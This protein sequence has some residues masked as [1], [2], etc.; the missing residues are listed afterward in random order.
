M[1]VA[2]AATTVKRWLSL[3][4]ELEPVGIHVGMVTVN[5]FVKPGTALDPALIADA[6]RALFAQE[7][8]GWERELVLSSKPA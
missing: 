8:S 4:K 7:R 3:A 2:R 5:G 1:L 6:H